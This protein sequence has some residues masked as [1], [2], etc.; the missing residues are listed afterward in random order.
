VRH[1]YLATALPALGEPGSRPPLTPAELATRLEGTTAEPLARAILLE[2]DLIQRD[3]CL[4]GELAEPRS[5]VLSPGQARGQEPLPE[6]LASGGERDP[7]ATGAVP[8]DALWAAYWRHVA[9]VAAARRSAFLMAW[10]EAEVGLRNALA[11]ARA[12]ALG[13]DPLRY[14]VAPELAGPR[15]R[16]D[17]V[18]AAWSAAPNPL[19]GLQVLLRARW[20]WLDHEGAR[21]SFDDDELASYTA[22]LAV[23]HRW[24][25]A[26]HG[27]RGSG[28]DG[29]V[30]G[31]VIRRE[32]HGGRGA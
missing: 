21:Y 16:E 27:A 25:R 7:R 15:P 10:V 24:Y 30:P 6:D 32:P 1:Y 4:A 28:A 18:V 11:A 12:R 2:D 19:A 26:L 31:A 20:D 17:S 23:L 3:A 8:G 13:L 29:A 14:L 22:R 9:G 5:A